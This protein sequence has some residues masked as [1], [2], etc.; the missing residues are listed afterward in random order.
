MFTVGDMR[1]ALKG[2]HD[3]DPLAVVFF[4][5][6]NAEDVLDAELTYEQWA[7]IAI[8]FQRTESLDMD[9]A[10]CIRLYAQDIKVKGK[11]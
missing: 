10:E 5:K 7:H 3:A 11:K 1:K 4:T 6:E 9:A 2:K 8:K